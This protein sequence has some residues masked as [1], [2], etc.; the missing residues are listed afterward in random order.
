MIHGDSSDSLLL[1]N[2]TRK[3]ISYSFSF[4]MQMLLLFHTPVSRKVFQ[5]FDCRK[6]GSGTHTRAFLR[7]D[8]S[9]QCSEGGEDIL[10]YNS[11]KAPVWL[12]FVCF[13]LLLPLSLSSFLIRKRNILYT[14]SVLLKMGWMYERLNH[15]TEFWEIHELMRKML[16]TG[17]IVFFPPDP[18]IRSCLALLICIAAQCSLSYLKPHRNKIIFWVEEFAFMV[19]L[20]L[21][22]FSVAMQANMG[23]EANAQLGKAFIGGK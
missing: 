22:V 1:W 19:A 3:L 20:F 2:R 23:E 16:L 17:V 21:F 11:F 14:P 15:G 4:S 10:S 13:T 9:I 5:Y 8:Y 18:A 12:V 7:V 6:I